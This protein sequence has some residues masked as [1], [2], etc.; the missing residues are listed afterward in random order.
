MVG[1]TLDSVI[2][3]SDQEDSLK[4]DGLKKI[5]KLLQKNKVKQAADF[6]LETL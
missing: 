6:S 1:T 4:A 2:Y 3:T 5:N